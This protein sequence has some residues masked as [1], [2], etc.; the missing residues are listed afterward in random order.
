MN[1][2]DPVDASQQVDGQAPSAGPAMASPVSSARRRLI[3]LG[4]AAVPV[5]A[6]VA[7]RPALAWHCQTPSAWGSEMMDTNTSLKN[8]NSPYL[9]DETWTC[10]NWAANSD[11]GIGSKP[12]DKLKS[13]LGVGTTASNI[14]IG[15]VA[16][17]VSGFNAMGVATSKKITWAMSGSNCTNWVK[18]ALCAQLNYYTLGS[19]KGWMACLNSNSQAPSA[20]VIPPAMQQMILGTY[21]PSG[22]SSGSYSGTWSQAQVIAYFNN[23]WIAVLS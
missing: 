22:L 15:E 6:T 3:R 5:A 13:K 16:S 1:K 12:L 8:T 2:P 23:N 10:A 4:A 18:L 14:T 9:V 21:S 7:S 19:W 20:N 17:R 11:R